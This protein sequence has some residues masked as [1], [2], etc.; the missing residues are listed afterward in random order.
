M[1]SYGLVSRRSCRS[2]CSFRLSSFVSSFFRSV[3]FHLCNP[4]PLVPLPCGLRDA[5]FWSIVWMHSHHD[6]RNALLFL[7]SLSHNRSV[8]CYL[9]QGLASHF[10]L[11]LGLV[12]CFFG[13]F[14]LQLASFGL[15]P[16]IVR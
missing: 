16:S 6:C 15:S 8:Q 9:L 7:S 13:V 1:E 4:C 3:F 10:L 14:S 2:S 5:F 12:S 11:D